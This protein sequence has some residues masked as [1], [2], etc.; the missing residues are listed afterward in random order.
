MNSSVEVSMATVTGPSE[1]TAK[2]C[3]ASPKGVKGKVPEGNNLFLAR[4]A[5]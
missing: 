4:L 1:G 2:R 5:T 3:L